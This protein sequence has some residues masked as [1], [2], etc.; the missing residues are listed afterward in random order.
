MIHETFHDKI[1]SI[2][3]EDFGLNVPLLLHQKI[4][5][6]WM[7]CQEAG[8]DGKGGGMKGGILADE[9]RYHLFFFNNSADGIGKNSDYS[10]TYFK[11][12]RSTRF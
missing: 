9:V 12:A 2:S 5:L 7:Q 4:A 8:P 6:A 10:C 1:K 11:Q 3:E